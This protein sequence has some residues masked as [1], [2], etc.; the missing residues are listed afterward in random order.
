MWDID[1]CVDDP[2]TNQS[3]IDSD[4]IGDV[5]DICPEDP[6]NDD[7]YPNGICDG[8]D[9]LGC[10]DSIACNYNPEATYDDGSCQYL[11]GICD[12]CENGVLV[13]ND[14][15]ND[16]DC[17]NVDNCFDVYNPNQTDSDGDGLGNPCDICPYDP[18]NDTTYPNGICDN[19]DILG[20]TDNNACNYDEN[21]TYD[22][23][24]CF[25]L[26]G[27]CETC[28]YIDGSIVDNDEDNDGVCND[29]EIFGCYDPVACN[30]NIYATNPDVC[31]YIADNCDYCSGQIDGTGIVI[32]GDSDGDGVC[33]DD[34]IVGCQEEEA[35]NYNP[36]ATDP[37]NCDYLDGICDTC[38]NGCIN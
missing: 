20:C 21:A 29:D 23:L 30:Y 38:E 6:L 14:F 2:N 5:C 36:L 18:T 10:M 33:N 16:E 32:N 25:Y 22:D 11:D 12:T 9:I 8:S 24:S 13:D 4:G 7:T 17:D 26:D 28:E 19:L 27:I 3:D 37:A 1:N 15:D 34:E 35:C 31:I